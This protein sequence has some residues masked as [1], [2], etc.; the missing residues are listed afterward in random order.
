MNNFCLIIPT[1]GDRPKFIQQCKRL[2]ARQTLK[3][4]GIIWMDYVPESGAKDITQR[5]KRGVEQ[6]T[7]EGYQFVVFWEDDDWYHPGYLEWLIKG[8]KAQGMPN[9]FG[10]GE[11]YYY[12]LGL[13]SHIHMKHPGRTSMFCTL[14]KLPWRIKWPKDT[15]PF[16]DMHIH[17]STKV[18]TMNFPPERIY[19]IGIKHGIGL[20]GGGG[21]YSRMSY[22]PDKKAWFNKWLGS[23]TE[24]YNKIAT[25]LAP[26][27]QHSKNRNNIPKIHAKPNRK[28]ITANTHP[29]LSRRGPSIKKIRRK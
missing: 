22:Q 23:D 18:A 20:A 29:Q 8:W 26:I 24:F 28:I 25:E 4:N 16:L 5:Y 11:T 9:F 14:A 10:V 13:E 1:R 12:H 7:K 19:A 17:R 3:P 2:I 21:H 27:A 15:Q 6:A